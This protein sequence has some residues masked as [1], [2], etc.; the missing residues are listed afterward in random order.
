M[1]LP[2]PSL[3]HGVPRLAFLGSAALIIPLRT[4]PQLLIRARELWSALSRRGISTLP[5]PVTVTPG[6]QQPFRW[7][8][9]PS[10]TLR[11]VHGPYLPVLSLSFA[12]TPFAT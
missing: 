12:L 11:R 9:H 5:H 6:A 4:A 7:R 3:H 2:A 1:Q 10:A 8:P